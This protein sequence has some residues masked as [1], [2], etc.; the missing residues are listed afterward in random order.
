MDGFELPCFDMDP[1]LKTT[2]ARGPGYDRGYTTIGLLFIPEEAFYPEWH[3][4]VDVRLH[5]FDDSRSAANFG[6]C[7]RQDYPEL[8]RVFGYNLFY[9]FREIHHV[10]H[11]IGLGFEMFSHDYDLFA[12]IYLPIGDRNNVWEPRYNYIYPN[13]FYYIKSM[14][15]EKSLFGGD[16]EALTSMRRWQEMG[17]LECFDFY[18][19]IGSYF[20][21]QLCCPNTFGGKF[22]VGGNYKNFLCVEIKASHDNTYGTNFQGVITI[23]FNLDRSRY[24]VPVE[25]QEIITSKRCRAW[26][27]NF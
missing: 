24:Y 2:R 23:N 25:R 22:R 17:E 26:N 27:Y 6:I 13:N 15:L 20:Y 18:A 12:N 1:Y 8:N 11:Q 19:G 16:I 9:D 21:F 7:L 5:Y 4:M 14:I 10:N 3:P